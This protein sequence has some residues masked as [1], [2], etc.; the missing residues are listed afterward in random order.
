MTTSQDIDVQELPRDPEVEP[1]NGFLRFPDG[2]LW[3]A[4]TAAYQIEGAAATDGRTP[5]I[6]DTFSV[7][8][9]YADNVGIAFSSRQFNGYGTRPEGIRNRMFGTEG[10]LETEYGGQ[11]LVRGKQFYNGGKTPTI[12]EQG[13]IGNIAAFHDAIQ[14]GDY[15]NG[16]VGESVRSQRPGPLA[17]A[18]RPRKWIALSSGAAM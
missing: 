11:V 4:A 13:A 16:T 9:T 3:G 2:F 8:Y 7:T 14:R 1:A 5:S 6:W 17:A 10:V 18:S 15:S 12:Y